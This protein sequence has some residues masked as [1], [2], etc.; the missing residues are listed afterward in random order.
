MHS[1]VIL[2]ILLPTLFTVASAKKVHL[3]TPKLQPK[4]LH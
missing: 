3:I 1:L 4:L 2:I